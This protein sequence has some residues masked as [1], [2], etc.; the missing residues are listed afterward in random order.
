ADPC[1][2]HRNGDDMVDQS[3][4]TAGRGLQGVLGVVGPGHG[5]AELGLRYRLDVVAAD[6]AD[7]VKFAGGW[8]FDRAM[9]G[10]DVTV[11]LVDHPENVRCRSWVLRSS[12]WNTPWRRRGT[13]R[14]H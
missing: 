14:H 7:V 11:L 6:V 12:I 1:L 2:Y 3:L 13:G 8:L 4:D 9:A 5:T 10:W